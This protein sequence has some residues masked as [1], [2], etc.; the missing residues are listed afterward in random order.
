MGHISYA[1][2]K[3]Y[4]PSA[5]TGMDLDSST[6]AP[7]VCRG[8]AV[9]KSMCQPFSPSKSKQTTEILQ[10]VH[11][12]LAG[13]LQT[14]SIQG[15]TYIATFIDDHSKHA[16]LY[17]LKS[18]DQLFEAL[19]MYLAWAETQPSHKMRTLHTDQ[20]GEYMA[21]QVQALLKERGIEHQTTMPGSPLS[22]F[23]SCPTHKRM[24][25]Q[26]WR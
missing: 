23:P 18:K 1:A 20:G 24:N 9:A 11:S 22:R 6:S 19:K 25:D 14:R 21:G 13:P 12:D 2:L 17:F 8:C 3:S 10:V 16:I 7:S 15:S 26:Q 5:L 4:G